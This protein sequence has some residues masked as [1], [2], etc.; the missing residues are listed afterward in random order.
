MIEARERVAVHGEFDVA[1]V[2]GGFAGTMVAVHLAARA[3]MP[4]RCVIF[5]SAGAFGRGAAYA[6]SSDRCLLNVRAKAMSAFADDESHFLRWLRHAG[7]GADDTDLGNRFLPRKVYGEYLTDLLEGCR[8]VAPVRRNDRVVDVAAIEDG[9]VLRDAAGGRTFAK[10]VVLALGNLPPGGRGDATLGAAMTNL[11]YPAWSFLASGELPPESD[12]LVIG[13]GLTALDVLLHLSSHG[14]RGSIQMLSRHGRFPLAHR[15]P[16]TV[17]EQPPPTFRAQP[18]NVIGELR[19][20]VRECEQRGNS[21][22]DAVDAIRPHTSALWQSWTPAQK[23]QFFRHVAPFWEIHRHRAPDSTLR[24]RDELSAAGRLHVRAGTLL[25]LQR[26]G[27]RV[28]ARYVDRKLGKRLAIAADAVIDCTGPRRDY[29]RSGDPLIEAL[30]RRGLA[31][32]DPLGIGFEAEA[33][34]ALIGSDTRAK[35]IFALGTPLRGKLYECGSVREVRVQAATVARA[36]FDLE[37]RK[38]VA[39]R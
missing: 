25:S 2:G 28:Q 32:T 1:I 19:R 6:P 10:R 3:A 36:L 13:T 39:S 16:P 37:E 26:V 5:D 21:W 18:K 30:F 8:D 34:G 22:H 38:V 4:P 17:P 7:Y 35:G 11:A 9:Y 15:P 29:R 14:H 23:A 12:V 31:M 20:F 27:S 24:L 33:D